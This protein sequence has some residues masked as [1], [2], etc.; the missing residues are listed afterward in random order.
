[1][2]SERICLK[3][4]YILQAT[5]LFWN[6]CMAVM[7]VNQT[8]FF[9]P[10]KTIS[11]ILHFIQEPEHFF[12]S[13][14]TASW[15]NRRMR[16]NALCSHPE[17]AGTGRSPITPSHHTQGISSWNPL[18]GEGW[19]RADGQNP[20]AV[21]K[22]FATSITKLLLWYH[23]TLFKQLITNLLNIRASLRLLEITV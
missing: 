18:S 19:E 21:E 11:G 5:P 12:K 4:F 9:L 8:I 15:R 6:T 23:N 2:R 13:K 17:Q 16:G 14:I 3:N 7:A 1:M 22:Q 10:Y 20:L